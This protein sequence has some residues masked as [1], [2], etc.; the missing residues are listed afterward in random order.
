MHK[1][2][3][4]GQFYFIAIIVL[5]VIF[6]GFITVFNKASVPQVPE[7]SSQVTSLNTEINY[8]LDYFAS[9]QISGSSA[10]Q[11]LTNFSN[12]YINEIGTDKN[13]FFI[14]GDSPTVNLVGN[15]LNSSA[16][17]VNYGSGNV[18]VSDNGTFQKTYTLSG[19]QTFIMSVDGTQSN[20]TFYPGENVYYLIESLQENQT[21]FLRG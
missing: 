21:F 15:K 4:K 10:N 5:A 19:T 20:F 9:S 18:T 2:N 6:I 16:I 13:V 14:F 11:V 7:L 8:L 17:T 1:K 12:Y 3:K